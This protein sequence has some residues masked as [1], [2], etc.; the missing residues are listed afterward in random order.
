[1]YFNSLILWSSPQPLGPRGLVP[2]ANGCTCCGVPSAS[3]SSQSVWSGDL[4]HHASCW[5]VYELYSYTLIWILH[6]V[7][8]FFCPYR[9]SPVT[10]ASLHPEE[11][12]HRSAGN[13]L[14]GST[15]DVADTSKIASVWM[16]IMLIYISI[17]PVTRLLLCLKITKHVY[18]LINIL[19]NMVQKLAYFFPPK[20]SQP[21][22]LIQSEYNLLIYRNHHST[23]AALHLSLIY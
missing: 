14:Q 10:L 9:S 6:S 2:V 12:H 18:T 4:H 23:L 8:P 16:S 1:M 13:T 20:I 3:Q 17:W 19:K 7:L 22:T 11:H 15:C 5:T 21:N